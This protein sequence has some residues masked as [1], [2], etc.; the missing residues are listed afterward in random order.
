MFLLLSTCDHMQPESCSVQG[1]KW[2]QDLC[3]EKA[4][5]V[6][7]TTEKYVLRTHLRV[8]LFSDK[9][10]KGINVWMFNCLRD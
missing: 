1:S 7:R 6:L 3:H 2:R 10:F 5:N 4:R 8:D 9:G